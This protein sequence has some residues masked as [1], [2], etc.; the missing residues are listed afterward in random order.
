MQAKQLSVFALFVF[1]PVPLH[2][3][4]KVPLRV[5]T[6]RRL[7]KVLVGRQKVLRLDIEI[8]EIAAAA[9]R[10]QDFFTDLICTLEQENL[11]AALG[12]GKRSKKS[13]RTSAEY[14]NI[15][16]RALRESLCFVFLYCHRYACVVFWGIFPFLTKRR[17]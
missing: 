4:D 15:E 5:L 11:T 16:N 8:G 7:A 14:H 6:Q 2:Q 12:C 9:A 10:H 17:V 1:E 3:V 13:C